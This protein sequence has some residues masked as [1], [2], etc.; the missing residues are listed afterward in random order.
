M[1]TWI[2]ANPDR[3]KKYG[4]L[5]SELKS[6]SE[7]TNARQK[8]DVII[9]RFP[10]PNSMA[11]FGQIVAAAVFVKQGKTLNEQQK[12]AKL[13]EITEALKNR[14]PAFEREMLKF[15]LK[16]FDDLPAN[17]RFAAADQKFDNKKGKERRDAEATY[18]AQ[19]ADGPLSTPDKILELYSLS[20]SD[21]QA[22]HPLTAGLVDERIAL[23]GRGAKFA[24]NIDR[25]RLLYMQAL[26]EMKGDTT[27]YPDANLTLRFSYG[28]VKG[29]Q[30]REA[31]YRSPFTTMKGMIE[32]NTGENPFD[33]PQK[34]I[35]LQNA[36]DFGRYGEGDSVVLNFLST[37]DIIGG[38]SGSPILDA[39]GNQVGLCFD[40]NF[41]G[42]GNDFYYDPAVNRTISVD[43]RYVLFVTEKFSGAKWIVDEIKTVGGPKAKAATN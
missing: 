5:L 29:Y 43:I 2:A 6:L 19:I 32:K 31:E 15:F 34:L 26:T 9:R 41:E 7:E 11:V 25:L 28:N 36:H 38:N 8:R 30:S 13:A 39:N 24:A 21:F 22:K 4:T 1:A 23:A 17:Q 18:A 10:D 3:Q 20:W 12:A 42:L 16:A 40:G 27:V 33:A 14:E 35:D 37:T